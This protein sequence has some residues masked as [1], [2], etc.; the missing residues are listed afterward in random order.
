MVGPDHWGS[1]VLVLVMS[2]VVYCPMIWK[3]LY[4]TGVCLLRGCV[5]MGG[6]CN[7]NLGIKPLM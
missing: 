6:P 7:D 2:L 4:L 1:P 3:I 5:L